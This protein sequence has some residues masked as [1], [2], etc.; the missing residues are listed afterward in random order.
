MKTLN[1]KSPVM[2]GLVAL[3]LGTVLLVSTPVLA[4]GAVETAETAV[5]KAAEGLADAEAALAH[6]GGESE[7]GDLRPPIPKIW[8]IAPIGAVVALI[9]AAKFYAEVKAAD[10]G[11]P[12]MIEIAGHVTQGAMA[13]LKRQYKVVSV[14]FV[15]LAGVLA[16]MGF[17]LKV[18]NPIVWFAFLTGGSSAACAATSGCGPPPW[19]A[20][21]PPPAPATRSTAASSSPSAPGPSWAFVVDQLCTAWTSPVWFLAL[22]L[23]APSFWRA[24]WNL[25]DRDRQSHSALRHGCFVAGTI[26]PVWAEVFTPRPPTSGADLVGKVEQGH[27]RRRRP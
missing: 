17:V 26:Q 18:Q 8:W 23:I 27:S 19:P 24:E 22:Y 16:F 1:V 13:Y 4:Q 2:W 15:V 9:F 3:A 25:V 11:D 20:T 7:V 12:E 10:P 5:E 6:A 21:E 14:V